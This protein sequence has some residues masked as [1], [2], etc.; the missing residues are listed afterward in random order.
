AVERSGSNGAERSAGDVVGD[1]RDSRDTVTA[2]TVVTAVT[3]VIAVTVEPPRRPKAHRGKNPFGLVFRV[4]V[5][6]SDCSCKRYRY[7][8]GVGRRILAGS[9]CESR[10]N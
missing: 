8:R 3:A 4:G 5:L 2:V 7:S 6:V 1:S 9:S 10:G